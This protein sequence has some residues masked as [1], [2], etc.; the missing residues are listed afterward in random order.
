VVADPDQIRRRIERTRDALSANVNALTEKVTPSRAMARQV[1]RT[2]HTMTN[3]KDKIM[4]TAE[5]AASTAADTASTI[6]E[7][8]SS[9]ASTTADQ[10]SSMA[11]SAVD[12]VT[13]APQ[14]V[15]RRAQ[16]NP[17]A[18]G[19]IAFGGGWLAAS[20]IQ[21]SRKERELAAQAKDR[22]A[23]QLEPLAK[24][25][26]EIASDVTD[27]LREP[28][29]QAVESVKST[30]SDAAASVAEEGRAALFG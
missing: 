29:Q 24:Q 13:S 6:G 19:L 18:A 1:D 26:K 25:A 21:S 12:A 7:T 17:L 16:G 2:R 23:D 11:S 4:G 22:L 30:A 10:V 5:D 8:A 20:L 15:R 28:V 9:V 14:A 27:T 3:V